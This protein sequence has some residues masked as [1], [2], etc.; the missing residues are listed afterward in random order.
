MGAQPRSVKKARQ[1]VRS[2]EQKNNVYIYELWCNVDDSLN[3]DEGMKNPVTRL[4]GNAYLQLGTHRRMD[5]LG[6]IHCCHQ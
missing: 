4:R 5:M 6:E 3:Y 1:R 2:G